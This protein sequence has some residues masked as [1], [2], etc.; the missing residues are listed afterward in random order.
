[1]SGQPLSITLPHELAHTFIQAI[2]A[3]LS[4]DSGVQL[5]FQLAE[6]ELCPM[7]RQPL[8]ITLPQELA[9][10]FIQ[11]IQAVVDGE[12]SYFYE[13]L[14]ADSARQLGFTCPD[15]VGGVL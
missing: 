13:E 1:M 9:H 12:V 4:T 6:P 14:W 2:Q 15:G 10:T 5:G 7:G 8:S 3:E 11:K